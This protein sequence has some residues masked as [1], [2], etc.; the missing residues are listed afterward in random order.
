MTSRA[1]TKDTHLSKGGTRVWNLPSVQ[2]AKPCSWHETASSKMWLL[3]PCKKAFLFTKACIF[4]VISSQMGTLF[5]FHK[6]PSVVLPTTAPETLH[7][8][9]G[10]DG[11]LTFPWL[12][13]YPLW[14]LS[15]IHWKQYYEPAMDQDN[16]WSTKNKHTLQLSGSL[17]SSWGVNIHLPF[18]K[19]C[20]VSFMWQAL[21]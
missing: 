21:W 14:Y 2:I 20:L 1:V 8:R 16:A 15:F 5:P 11:P 3:F 13:R 17:Q 18:I 10:Q 12:S 7:L 9:F 6:R 4:T 19:H